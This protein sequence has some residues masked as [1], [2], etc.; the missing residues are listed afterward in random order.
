VEKVHG[1][2]RIFSASDKSPTNFGLLGIKEIL[3]GISI[4]QFAVVDLA[5]VKAP[6]SHKFQYQWTDQR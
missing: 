4:E 6:R 3:P 5:P 1:L 2:L